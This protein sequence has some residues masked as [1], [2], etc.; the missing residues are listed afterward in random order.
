MQSEIC[1]VI[2]ITLYDCRSAGMCMDMQDRIILGVNKDTRERLRRLSVYCF[3]AFTQDSM[4]ITL[5]NY[6]MLRERA[7]VRHQGHGV[8]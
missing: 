2:S 1:I 5:Q 6:R 7:V 3:R 8:P 4:I